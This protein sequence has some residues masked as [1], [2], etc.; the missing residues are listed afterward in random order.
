MI[1]PLNPRQYMFRQFV[2]CLLVA[3]CLT[4]SQSHA[5]EPSETSEVT[6]SEVEPKPAET[7]SI[8]ADKNLEEAVR[9]EVYAKRYNSEPILAED[10]ATISRVVAKRKGIKSLAGL[11][12]CKR[13]MLLDLAGNEIADLNPLSELK[14]LQSVTISK[15]K[16]SDLSPIKGLKSMQL[17]DLSENQVADLSAIE[18]M[19][20]L[21][22]LYVS[23]NK[24]D[25]LSSLA[26]LT[27]LWSVDFSTNQVSDLAPI[28]NLK[29]LSTLNAD[30]NQV[31][32]L[33]PLKGLGELDL[34]MIRRNKIRDLT[35]LIEMCEADFNGD[36]KFA[37][38]LDI[39][40]SGNPI[41]DAT[42]NEQIQR[43]QALGV[44]VEDDQ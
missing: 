41:D 11:E 2:F 14:L 15:N 42:L 18:G 8:F 31:E 26:K 4:N 43:L 33:T 36:R 7:V 21:R 6:A 1:P 30:G 28:A 27:K 12:H 19:S 35:P 39:Y 5:D 17:L 32:S 10:V 25:D 24:I 37:P 44:D 34:M 20:N 16:I 3:T 9:A 38:Y 13:I 22:T 40:I 23:G 29:W